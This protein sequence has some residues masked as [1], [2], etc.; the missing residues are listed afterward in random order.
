MQTNAARLI[1]RG[2]SM[3]ADHTILV[4]DDDTML[5]KMAEELLSASYRVSLAKSGKHALRLLQ[6]GFIPDLILLD[7]DMP[8]MDG[9]ETISQIQRLEQLADIPVIFLT[10]LSQAE[11]ELRGLRAGA[12][13]YITK[14][15][16]RSILLARLEMHLEMGKRARRLRSLEGRGQPPQVDPDKFAALSDILSSTEQKVAMLIVLGYTNQEICEQLHYSYSYIKKIATVIFE[17]TGVKK[18]HE[19]RRYLM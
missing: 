1:Q 6:S 3:Q 2:D 5:L 10:G 8:E 17:K 16:V 4:V 13:D 18:R 14:P 9:Y 7:I 11:A 15:F 19:L 12:C